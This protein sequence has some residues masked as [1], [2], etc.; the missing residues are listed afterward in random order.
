MPV[1]AEPQTQ[2]HLQVLIRLQWRQARQ[3]AV[4]VEV[5]ALAV[6]AGAE[7]LVA[8]VVEISLR[9]RRS[10][11][12]VVEAFW[13]HGIPLR[14]RS[15]GADSRQASIKAAVFRREA[16]SCSRASSIV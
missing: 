13:W 8:A 15:A 5:R 2:L 12:P 9:F 7:A 6:R 16:I 1:A 14:K 3:P 4:P 10:V 11:Q